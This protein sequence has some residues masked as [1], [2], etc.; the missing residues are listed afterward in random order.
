MSATDQAFI[1]AYAAPGAPAISAPLRTTTATSEHPAILSSLPTPQA[2]A[3]AAPQ[4][5]AISPVANSRTTSVHIGLGSVVPAPH[6]AFVS[7]IAAAMAAGQQQTTSGTTS[8]LSAAMT[9]QASRGPLSAFSNQF[10]AAPGTPAA[11]RP[12]M[13]I[14]AARWPATCE[15]L[16]SRHADRF[17]RLVEHL[18]GEIASG[19][20]TL[21]ITGMH[22]RE[23]RTTLALCLARQLAAANIKLA[24]VD[25]D[26]ANPR[27]ASQLSIGVHRGWESVLC[28]EQ[29]PWDVMIEAMA[30]RLALLPMGAPATPDEISIG[31]YR[32]AA[33][34]N[35]L[36][37]HY[38]LVLIDAG[39]IAL[40][41]APHW[42]FDAAA[43]VQATILA[44]DARRRAPGQVA[45]GCL[46]LAQAGLRQLGLAEMFSD[47]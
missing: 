24:L 15:Q 20:R 44:Y 34:L 2:G 40:D 27:L 6:A 8:T 46:Q 22:R 1:R 35:E 43:G 23:G 42:L 38:D 5:P 28:G 37:E 19:V 39:P 31:S 47:E 12:A 9:G 16:L 25:A 13:E 3:A 11:P 36:A 30:D 29:S 14:D 41:G 18:R 33:T 45:A 10:S 21:A 32:I 4:S 17:A 26:F 7:K